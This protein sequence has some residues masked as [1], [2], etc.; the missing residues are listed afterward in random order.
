MTDNELKQEIIDKHLFQN[1]FIASKFRN[2]IMKCMEEWAGVISSRTEEE[3]RDEYESH[4]NP[5]Y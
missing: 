1:E 4:N 5:G 2:E 3:V